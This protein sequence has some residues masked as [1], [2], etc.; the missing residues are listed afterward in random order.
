MWINKAYIKLSSLDMCLISYEL[1][2]I[3]IF[4]YENIISGHG[5]IDIEYHI[6]K[7]IFDFINL[8]L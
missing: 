7:D 1:W 4:M 8:I 3:A 5:T 6:K 2:S